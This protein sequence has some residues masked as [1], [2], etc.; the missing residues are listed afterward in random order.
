[1]SGRVGSTELPSWA[2]S[3]V[4]SCCNAWPLIEEP[5]TF[6]PELFNEKC[7]NPS[8]IFFFKAVFI[9]ARPNAQVSCIQIRI[10]NDPQFLPLSWFFVQQVPV[11]LRESRLVRSPFQ[12]PSTEGGPWQAAHWQRVVFTVVRDCMLMIIHSSI[13]SNHRALPLHHSQMLYS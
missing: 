7:L 3:L 13:S 9:E 6:F 10:E 2:C 4:P 5:V 12:L 8:G 1:M 11:F